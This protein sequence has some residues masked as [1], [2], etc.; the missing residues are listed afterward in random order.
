MCLVADGAS[1]TEQGVVTAREQ[2]SRNKVG[3]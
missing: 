2:S 3:V 1:R